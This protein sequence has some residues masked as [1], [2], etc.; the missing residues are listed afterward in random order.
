MA[1]K[2]SLINS[3]DLL[4]TKEIIIKFDLEILG[5]VDVYVAFREVTLTTMTKAIFF[6]F[7]FSYFSVFSMF[8]NISY[9][10][11]KTG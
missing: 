1:L 4:S 10:K 8:L 6:I 11:N 5:E 2:V 9:A 7:P 3:L